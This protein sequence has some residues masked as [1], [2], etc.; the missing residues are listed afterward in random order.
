MLIDYDAIFHCVVL[1]PG[2]L[3]GHYHQWILL[4][5]RWV[6]GGGYF[7]RIGAVAALLHR[8]AGD[9]KRKASRIILELFEVV[10]KLLL[11]SIK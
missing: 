6:D 3:G 2:W 4:Y 8:A 5:Y 1:L 11:I 7:R 10:L 9:E